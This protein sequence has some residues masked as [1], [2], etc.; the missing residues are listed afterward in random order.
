M[1][2]HARAVREDEGLPGHDTARRRILAMV[3]DFAWNAA[4]NAVGS[5]IG[6]IVGV[7]VALWME[8][9]R[10]RV[11]NAAAA[12]LRDQDKRAE[13][14]RRRQQLKDAVNLLDRSVEANIAAI[15]SAEN[16]VAQGRYL[17]AS[18]IELQTW[19]VLKPKVV[20]LIDDL[21]FVA[22]LAQFFTQVEVFDKLIEA[23]ARFAARV[24]APGAQANVILRDDITKAAP[25]LRHHCASIRNELKRFA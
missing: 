12:T 18:G 10:Q 22:T 25:Q 6:V 17:F 13:D 3:S 19:D 20:E 7:P 1:H 4:A 2:R 11:E 15:R 8:R 23:R 14:E 24:D 21:S 9:R 16:D 5:L